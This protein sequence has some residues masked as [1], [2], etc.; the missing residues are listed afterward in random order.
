MKKFI[1]FYAIFLFFI[2]TGN[3]KSQYPNYRIFPSNY[4]Q[5]EPSIVKHPLNP[6][7]LFASAYTIYLSYR[8]EGVYV[9]T[10]GGLNWTGVDSVRG[11]IPQNH[12]GDPGPIIDKD[13]RF[14]ITHQG[15]FVS[16][17]YSDYSTNLGNTWTST[18]GPIATGDNDKG[19]PQTDDV[20]SSP[21]YGRT[22]LAWTRYVNPFPIVLSYTT[23]GAVNWSSIIQINTRYSNN[24]S[25]GPYVS[26]GL[27][28]EVYVSWASSLHVSPFT[29]DVI[30]FAKSTNGG[31]SWQVQENAFDC[32]GIRT[33]QLNPWNIR[34]NSFPVMDVDKTGGS[35]SG[36]IYIATAEKN[37]APAG[38]DP[39][40]IFHKSTNNGSTWSQG[41][42]VNQ[43]P[44]NNG[45]N[46]FFPAITV[47]ADGGIN[48]I[49]YDNRHVNDSADVYLSRSTDGGN[50][51]SDHLVT[52]QRFKPRAVAGAIGT[53]NMGDN[54]GI[55][56]GNG[57][58]YPV[59]MSNQP[60]DI[61]H[62]WSA[63]I[64]YATIG[65]EQISSELPQEFLLEQNYP[66]PFNPETKINFSVAKAGNTSIKIY[67]ITG[68]LVKTLVEQEMRPGKYS[69]SWNAVNEPSGVYFYSIETASF[70]Q[71]KKMMLLK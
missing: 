7:I 57:K 3:V 68:R 22:Y 61:F 54:L 12:G 29:E 47:D 18:A 30:G 13:G 40:I 62:V 28:G 69:V 49:Y 8:S 19:A 37:L 14:I 35:R 4:N 10:N 44:L 52:S 41:V 34:A 71:S 9:S 45:R 17:M 65:I 50:T 36:W 46:Q 60:D 48:I 58:L 33:T 32:N 43:D 55:T 59:W 16:G 53:G 66:N 2:S 63:I 5:I 31:V 15:G 27:G 23:N 56:S 39:D 20:S 51:W 24:N 21:Y 70:K 1:I 26:V 64:D 11:T 67:D 25:Y 42:R 6:Q 38:T